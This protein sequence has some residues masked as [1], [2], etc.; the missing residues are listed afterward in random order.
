MKERVHK[1]L[2]QKNVPLEDIKKIPCSEALHVSWFNNVIK[3]LFLILDDSVNSNLQ[4]S[5]LG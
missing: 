3:E 4:Y 5:M 2:K 1:T